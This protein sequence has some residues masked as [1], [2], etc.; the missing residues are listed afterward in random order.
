MVS[1]MAENPFEDFRPSSGTV[2]QFYYYPSHNSIFKTSL[3]SGARKSPLYDPYVGKLATFAP[4]RDEA[5]TALKKSLEHITIKGIHTNLSFLK[6]LLTCGDILAANTHIDFVKQ[7]CNWEKRKR[8]DREIQVA[9]ALLAA[10][11][12]VENR[13]KDYK[14]DLAGRKQPGFFKRLIYRFRGR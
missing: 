14:V 5:I 1:L 6:H 13:R 3:Y 12:H 11:F 2:N 9:A 8:S 7:K 4:G 10:A